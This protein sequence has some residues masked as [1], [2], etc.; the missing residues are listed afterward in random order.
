MREILFKAKRKNWRELPKEEW[1]VEG[2]PSYGINGEISEIEHWKDFAN[3]EVVEIDPETLCQYTGLKDKDGN[4]IWE[5]DI[6]EAW[7]EGQKAIGKV[8][9]RIDG[10]YIM[11]PA[12]QKKFWGL[13]PDD[14]GETTVN[15][16][17]NI[18]DNPELLE[19]I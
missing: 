16:I 15:I 3:C 9:R 14:L 2:L 4:R 19:R 8:E 18:F 11:Y 7:S 1:W 17:G 12:Y 6:V 5:N 10:L 13:R